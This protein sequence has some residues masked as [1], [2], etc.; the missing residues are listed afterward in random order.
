MKYHS[1]MRYC[2]LSILFLMLLRCS[3]NTSPLYK[4]EEQG[5]FGYADS[6]GHIVINPIYPF[7]FTDTLRTIAFVVEKGEIIAINHKGVSLFR[8]FNYDNGPD[9]VREGLFRIVDENDLVG[10]ADTLG[11]IVIVPQYKFGHSFQDGKAQVT[12][13]GQRVLDGEYWRWSS[14]SWFYIQHPQLNNKK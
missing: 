5:L 1:F 6:K 12:N 7:A 10:Y 9:Y 4:I 11:N 14:K 13:H 2:F 8:V 3:T